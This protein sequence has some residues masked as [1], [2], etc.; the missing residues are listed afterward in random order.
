LSAKLR[1]GPIVASQ[2]TVIARVVAV[3]VAVVV[4]AS[5]SA[6]ASVSA[7]A[8]AG[9]SEPVDFSPE[10]WGHLSL[11]FPQSQTRLAPSWSA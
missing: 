2:S 10:R 11:L 6:A 1:S 9:S 8:S 4:S 7:S 3:A 5:A